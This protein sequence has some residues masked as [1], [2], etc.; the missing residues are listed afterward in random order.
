MREKTKDYKLEDKNYI[1]TAYNMITEKAVLLSDN[2]KDDFL[3]R[4]FQKI[5][6]EEYNKVFK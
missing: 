2:L 1:Q 6:I 5:I 4:Y 3:N